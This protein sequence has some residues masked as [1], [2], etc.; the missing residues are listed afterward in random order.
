M[1]H[2]NDRV[3]FNVCALY[4]IIL[5]KAHVNPTTQ[6]CAANIFQSEKKYTHVVYDMLLFTALARRA[7]SIKFP[8]IQVFPCSG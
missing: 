2:C 7:V 4:Y 8:K 1:Y 6:L 5:V 3:V